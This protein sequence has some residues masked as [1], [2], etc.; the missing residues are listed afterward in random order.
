[1]FDALTSVRPYKPALSLDE[2]LSIMEREAGQHFDPVIYVAFRQIAPILYEQGQSRDRA[3]WL[4]EL[5]VM[6]ERYFKMKTAPEGAVE[7]A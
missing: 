7:F 2:T 5:K 1:V 4:L 3:Q 6:L